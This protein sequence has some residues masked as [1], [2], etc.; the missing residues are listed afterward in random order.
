[1]AKVGLYSADQAGR[2]RR[3]LLDLGFNAALR[4]AVAGGLI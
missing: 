1:M 3:I 2:S 4:A